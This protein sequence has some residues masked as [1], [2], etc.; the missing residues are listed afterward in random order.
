MENPTVYLG[1]DAHKKECV[2]CGL[3][4]EGNRV[5]E[6]KTPTCLAGFEFVKGKLEGYIVKVV[7]EAGGFVWKITDLFSEVGFQVYVCNPS[8]N[9][10]IGLSRKKTDKEDAF[11][12]ADLLR[13]GYLKCIY[14][15]TKEQRELRSVSRDRHSLG[16]LR[17]RLL[18][19]ARTA[20]YEHQI[21][22]RKRIIE[23]VDD[24][25]KSLKK[26]I[27]ANA[28]KNPSIR[29]LDST[30][31]IAE[32]G[33]NLIVGEICTIDRFPTCKQYIAYC[34]LVPSVRQSGNTLHLGAIRKDSNHRLKWV[35]TQS[36]WIAVR[37][38]QELRRLY[39]RKA[40]E[41]GKKKAIIVVAKKLATR[42]YWMLKENK[43]YQELVAAFIRI[44]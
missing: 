16:R 11:K 15:P 17:G 24:E 13:A 7:V 31:G 19:Q 4:E 8:K 22:R 35:Y 40:R 29:L 38:N 18:T 37:W 21:E 36:A 2:F 25:I 33:A 10:Q 39:D 5:W 6:G 3:N 42:N 27:T 32:Y 30:P 28:G 20:S 34:G 12:L 1:C 23:C 44:G 26:E 14:I 9:P 43:T 41:R